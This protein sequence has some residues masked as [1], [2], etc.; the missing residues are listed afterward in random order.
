MEAL[1]GHY[2]SA[3]IVLFGVNRVE[4]AD[5]QAQSVPLLNLPRNKRETIELI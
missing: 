2:T 4:W 3:V 1:L 5:H